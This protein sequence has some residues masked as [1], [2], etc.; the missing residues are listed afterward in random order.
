MLFRSMDGHIAKPI[1]IPKLM[2]LLTDIL[3]YGGIRNGDSRNRREGGGI[4]QTNVAF[5]EAIG[6]LVE[7]SRIV[8][9]RPKGD[10]HK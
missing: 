3:K 5:W 6:K 7:C 9:G 1:D 10:A 4:D 2:D 8:I